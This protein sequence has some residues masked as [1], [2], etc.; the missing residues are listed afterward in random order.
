M[1]TILTTLF[2]LSLLCFNNILSAKEIIKE[3]PAKVYHLNY[4]VD[5]SITTAGLLASKFGTDYLRDREP[6]LAEIP[7]LTPGDIWWFDRGATKVNPADASHSL[8][9][10]DDWVF[11][12]KIAPAILLLDKNINRYWYDIATLY[13]EAHAIHASAYLAAAIPIKRYRPLMYNPSES[14]ERKTGENTTNAFFSGHAGMA[15]TS[16]FFM[17]KVYLDHHPEIKHKWVYYTGASIP[18]AIVGY[19]RYKAGKHFP[20]DILVGIAFGAASG[21]LVPEWHKKKERKLSFVP[22]T[23]NYS[24]GLYLKLKLN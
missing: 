19:Y 8:K 7:T 1:K 23:N 21:I 16:M 22:Y 13:L 20:T 24:T 9:L 14:M 5:G 18:P 10:S 4:L 17:A 15:A 6:N 12:T 3:K 2:A 11:Y